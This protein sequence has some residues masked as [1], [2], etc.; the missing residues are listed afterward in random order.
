MFPEVIFLLCHWCRAEVFIAKGRHVV[1][2]ICLWEADSDFLFLIS[3]STT[4]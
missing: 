4:L 1:F 2:Q 3:F